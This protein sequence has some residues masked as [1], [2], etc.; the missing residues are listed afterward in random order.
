MS[1]EQLAQV[2]LTAIYLVVQVRR[3]LQLPFSMYR[4]AMVVG[5]DKLVKCLCCVQSKER[6]VLTM[7]IRGRVITYRC[8]LLYDYPGNK[9]HIMMG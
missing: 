4:M 1:D 2:L 7:L 9:Y 3:H 8:K 5:R 6:K